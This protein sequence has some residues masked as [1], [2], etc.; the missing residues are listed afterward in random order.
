MNDPMTPTT[1]ILFVAD[2]I[3]ALVVFLLHREL[4]RIDATEEDVRRLREEQV[5]QAEKHLALENTHAATRVEF[6]TVLGNIMKQL[7]RILDRLEDRS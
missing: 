1:L 5:R 6:S 3:L 7:D 4:K 2:G